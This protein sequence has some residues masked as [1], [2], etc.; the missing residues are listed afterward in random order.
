MEE[1][2][3]EGGTERWTDKETGREKECAFISVIVFSV[4]G[5]VGG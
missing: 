1:R 2:C 4:A 3:R 5:E